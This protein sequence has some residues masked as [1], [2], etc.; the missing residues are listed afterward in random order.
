MDVLKLLVTADLNIFFALKKRKKR[1]SPARGAKFERNTCQFS[2]RRD[3]GF[4]GI[5]IVVFITFFFFCKFYYIL[6]TLFLYDF[7]IILPY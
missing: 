1:V 5:Y 7:I 4:A 3:S 2:R 6:L